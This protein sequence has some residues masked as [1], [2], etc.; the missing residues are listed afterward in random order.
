[1]G[2]SE[3][4]KKNSGGLQNFSKMG[5]ENR[6][7]SDFEPRKQGSEPWKRGS[8]PRFRETKRAGISRV[9]IEPKYYFI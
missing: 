7:F 2:H 5:S 4:Q 6:H 1:M 8:E 3:H 9:N